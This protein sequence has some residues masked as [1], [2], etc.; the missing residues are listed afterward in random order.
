M[1]S[2]VLKYH[3]STN[4]LLVFNFGY[5][6][7]IVNRQNRCCRNT[8]SRRRRPA[9]PQALHQKIMIEANAC[10]ANG[11]IPDGRFRF[12][13]GSG[14][15]VAVFRHPLSFDILLFGVRCSIPRGT[16]Q[17]F[18]VRC[19]TFDIPT[20]FWHVFI[21]ESLIQDGLDGRVPVPSK[22]RFLI[23]LCI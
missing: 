8:A 23:R 7:R 2:V 9:R 14:V 6:S 17:V 22:K 19:S 12:A 18:S 1:K 13:P 4:K 21:Y 11:G 15:T 16:V 3:A 10:P 20:L 5:N